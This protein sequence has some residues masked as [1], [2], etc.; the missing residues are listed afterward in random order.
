MSEFNHPGANERVEPLPNTI[1]LHLHEK[2]GF[3][4]AGQSKKDPT[5]AVNGVD[6]EDGVGYPPIPGFTPPPSLLPIDMPVLPP[7]MPP[8]A[9][10]PPAEPGP[11]NL[12]PI[13]G[14][15]GSFP[16]VYQGGAW[17]ATVEVDCDGNQVDPYWVQFAPCCGGPS[18][19]IMEMLGVATG[20]PE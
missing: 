4:L 18:A 8:P 3:G 2:T 11:P 7:F 16:F 14:G 10:F 19:P 5:N 15:G 9:V 13:P 12:P 20:G 17:W 1:P 6:G